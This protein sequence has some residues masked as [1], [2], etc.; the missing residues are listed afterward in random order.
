M[1]SHLLEDRIVKHFFCAMS[2]ADTQF[3]W[4]RCARPTFPKQPV[5]LVGKAA[6]QRGRKCATTRVARS[7][8]MARG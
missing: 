2:T 3:S 4:R 6:P 7:A 8:I 5:R 1:I